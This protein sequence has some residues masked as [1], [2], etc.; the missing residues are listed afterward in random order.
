MHT[1]VIKETSKKWIIVVIVA[2]AIIAI[3]TGVNRL[4]TSDNDTSGFTLDGGDTA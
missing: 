2:L 4:E 1:Y 3:L